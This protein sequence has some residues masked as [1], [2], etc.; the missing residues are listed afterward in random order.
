MENQSEYF[1]IYYPISPTKSKDLKGVFATSTVTLG[2]ILTFNG[3]RYQVHKIRLIKAKLFIAS[4]KLKFYQGEEPLESKVRQNSLI[5]RCGLADE[6]AFNAA[7]FT[8]GLV[9]NT[10]I[11]RDLVLVC[12][13]SEDPFHVT[14]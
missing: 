4:G 2:S 14:W 9:S 6:K 12:F 5:Q 10:C 3:I 11:E 7:F 1:K 13:V 8:S